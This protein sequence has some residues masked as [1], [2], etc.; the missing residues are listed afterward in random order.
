[1]TPKN[2]NQ[3]R[4]EAGAEPEVD[5]IEWQQHKQQAGTRKKGLSL[6]TYQ[7]DLR[8]KRVQ[9]RIL[10]A[11]EHFL[12]YYLSG[13]ELQLST[14][15]LEGYFGSHGN[16]MFNWMR[17]N[18]L[19][20][21][22]SY[23]TWDGR[24]ITY[25]VNQRGFDKLWVLVHHRTFDFATERARQVE[26]VF[27]PYIEGDPLPL[28]QTV[29][30][31]RLYGAHQTL[32]KCVRAVLLKGRSDYDIQ[33]A[34]PTLVL[35]SVSDDW[36]KDFPNWAKYLG[37]RAAFRELLAERYGITVNQAKEL[38][39][40]LFDLRTFNGSRSGIGEIIGAEKCKKAM[41]DEFLVRLR[42]EATLAWAAADLE[43]R[44]DGRKRFAYYEQLEQQ[45]MKAIYD[46]ATAN[47]VRYWPFHDGFTLLEKGKRI[48]DLERFARVV[49][50]MTG[51]MILLDEKLL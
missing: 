25:K 46:I 32:E 10:D 34:M 5:N 26:P 48:S 14:K 30:G 35:Q 36:L 38:F 40:G 9:K 16:E 8:Q 20:E 42:D 24:A 31:G 41:S 22:R 23:S 45:V 28:H 4:A 3:E 13:R 44:T 17:R 1:L 7:P 18:L 51:Y 27:R 12:P 19:T 2:K 33:A 50:E 29:E 11:L 49:R 15:V 6:S 37:S 47:G 39:Q 43:K 21:V